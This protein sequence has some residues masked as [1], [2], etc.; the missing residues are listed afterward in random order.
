MFAMDPEYEHVFKLAM[1]TQ[2]AHNT[3]PLKACS[4]S[5]WLDKRK[6]KWVADR[7]PFVDC[8]SFVNENCNWEEVEMFQSSM[9][10]F[11]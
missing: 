8:W 6:P 2:K 4:P 3:A 5:A 10:V 7:A 1:K 11:M 9:F